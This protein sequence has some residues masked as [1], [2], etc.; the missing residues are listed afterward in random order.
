MLS[1][2][3]T[4]STQEDPCSPSGTALAAMSLPSKTRE[5]GENDNKRG[6]G[7]LLLRVCVPVCHTPPIAVHSCTVFSLPPSR[8]YIGE[9]GEHCP[10]VGAVAV[11]CPVDCLSTANSLAISSLG[12]IMDPLLVTFVQK[13]REQ[14]ERVLSLSPWWN[15]D[16]DGNDIKGVCVCVR[17]RARAV[18][19]MPCAMSLL[20]VTVVCVLVLE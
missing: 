20:N 3:C 12:Q 8:R 13:V 11:A 15:D 2:D 17:A 5:K 9:E 19:R 7:G 1:T 6:G 14:H 10:L 4:Q 16:D 18:G